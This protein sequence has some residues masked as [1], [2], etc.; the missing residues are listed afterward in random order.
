MSEP[1][2][3]KNLAQF[4]ER[5]AL[6]DETGN[7]L[8]YVELGSRVDA[9]A[10]T[11][12]EGKDESGRAGRRLVM[13]E[14][15]NTLT[16][17]VAYLAALRSE[18]AVIVSK[19]GEVSG[20]GRI[21]EQFRPSMTH[22]A[23]DDG[24]TCLHDDDPELNP[25]LKALYSTSGS[26]GSAK[27]VRLSSRNIESNADSIATY[28]DIDEHEVAPLVVPLSYPF[29]PS[30][31]NSHLI[32]GARVVL[33]EKSV[34][35][36][37]F[38]ELF[39]REECTSL[40][41][42]PYTWE[43]VE[44]AGLLDQDW[45]HLRTLTQAGGKMPASRVMRLGT[46]AREHNRRLFVMYGQTEC[47][48]RMAYLP[49]EHTL[50]HADCIGV[51]IPGGD[52]RLVDEDGRALES[53]NVR[54]ELVYAGPNVMMGYATERSDLALPAGPEERFT[55]DLAERNEL[56]L[57][58]IVGRLSRF[59]KIMGLRIDL[60]EVEAIVKREGFED[61][62][63]SGD[64]DL[65]AICVRKE[66]GQTDGECLT[67]KE[68]EVRI[69]SHCGIPPAA[70]AV[71]EVENE[72]PRLHNGKIDYV[73][74]ANRAREIAASRA[75]QQSAGRLRD[76]LALL[77]GRPELEDEDS[78]S[79]LGGDSL[80]YIQ[81][82]FAIERYLGYLPRGWELLSMQALEATEVRRSSAISI[83]TDVLLRGLAIAAVVYNHTKP[84]DSPPMPGGAA[85]LLLLAG[86][87]LARFRS[88][89]LFR[90]ESWPIVSS[91]FTRYVLPYLAI[92]VAYLI[93]KGQF[94]GPSLLL[95]STFV[96]DRTGTFL[97]PFWFME[98]FFHLTLLM[99]GVFS[100]RPLRDSIARAPLA[101]GAGAVALLGAMH[102]VSNEVGRALP[103]LLV[104]SGIFGIGWCVHFAKTDMA[105][106]LV[107]LSVLAYP[108]LVPRGATVAIVTL[109]LIWLPR[110]PVYFALAKDFFG[111][112]GAASFYI[113]ILHA[114][115]VTVLG[116]GLGIRGSWLFPV[117]GVSLSLAAG[118][119][120]NAGAAW[121]SS[122]RSRASVVVAEPG[123]V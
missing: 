104:F 5:I 32:R 65:I 24:F 2:F 103:A 3:V 49:W 46:W 26:T 115:V 106:A 13:V 4:G 10:D 70:V 72:F 98:V 16:S 77:L 55:G 96:S 59:S 94:D 111:K 99:A 108:W 76:E 118:V 66:D 101:W 78:F 18:H 83:D 43:L 35:D 9:L 28:L 45:P 61:S 87:N 44:R 79:K 112:V 116:S 102:V 100:I 7:R 36:P 80:T 11:L 82:S 17:A 27:L 109:I 29:A 71:V 120:F 121:L 122:R 93:A 107:S 33:T 81:A 74:I 75:D 73:T 57:Y 48:A 67:A 54:G 39:G 42:V 64:D 34:V 95:V 8:T 86:L 30:I 52:F 19:P 84:A 105:R 90:G 68:L 51:A 117:L 60:D 41:G 69:A 88:A 25:E 23:G 92:L 110:M 31:L 56:G 89:A 22:R 119:I 91:T 37:E 6:V 40:S 12:G 123:A 20:E 114:V 113:Y 63:V 38:K 58:R 1:A 62:Q 47:T 15:E 14:G 85:T 97:E 50:D 21:F 53:P